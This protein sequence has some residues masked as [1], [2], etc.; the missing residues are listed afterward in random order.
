MLSCH[1]RH[2]RHTIIVPSDRVRTHPRKPV[3]PRNAQRFAGRAPVPTVQ[4]YT[5]HPAQGIRL[6]RGAV[7]CVTSVQSNPHAV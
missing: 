7:G 3:V 2:R 1:H 5:A 4:G 6:C